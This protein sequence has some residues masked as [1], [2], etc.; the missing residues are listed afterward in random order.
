MQR[1]KSSPA[2]DQLVRDPHADSLERA[3]SIARLAFDQLYEF[4]PVFAA[5]LT[6]QSSDLREAAIKALLGR[7]NLPQYLEAGITLLHH[8]PD[9]VVR[10]DAAFALASY[11]QFTGDQR[12]RVMRE[13]VRCVQ[14]DTDPAVQEQC[15]SK[16]L[17]LLNGHSSYNEPDDFNRDR[18][19]DW[20]LLKPYLDDPAAH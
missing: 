4:E 10:S 15:Y 6:D 1:Y 17:A 20:E 5:L 12:E 9:W 11:V 14:H 19:V 7:W 13:L 3:S 2:D 18:D 16:F 8:D